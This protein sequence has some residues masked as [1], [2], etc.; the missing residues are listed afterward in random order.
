ME[1]E[2]YGLDTSGSERDRIQKLEQRLA[3]DEG[4]RA[5]IKF[6][7]EIT[8]VVVTVLVAAGI[9]TLWYNT[10][11]FQEA[12]LKNIEGTLQSQ[13]QTRESDIATRI[14]DSMGTRFAEQDER[15]LVRLE[16]M[17]AEATT[18]EAVMTSEAATREAVLTV[19]ALTREAALAESAAAIIEALDV[20]AAE[21]INA[22]NAL[23][24]NM[25]TA[26]YEAV[27]EKL[28][29]EV[30]GNAAAEYLPPNIDAIFE[31]RLK[32]A[33][34]ATQQAQQVEFAATAT[35]Q[36][37]EQEALELQVTPTP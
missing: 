1:D 9:A 22:L 21:K 17:T 28:T 18:R 26:V 4:R 14:N 32:Q 6:I 11:N 31:D 16:V 7:I 5:G 15:V 33:V 29:D 27:D 30:I 12:T 23:Q 10:R 2:N 25:G 37:V 20:N 13:A 24:D 8:A 34:A 35:Q 19:E 3:F 36:A